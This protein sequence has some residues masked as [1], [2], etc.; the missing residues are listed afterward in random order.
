MT[1]DTG[2]QL[3]REKIISGLRKQ[4]AFLTKTAW[5]LTGAETF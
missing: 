5:L 4:M 2:D 3:P 1:A